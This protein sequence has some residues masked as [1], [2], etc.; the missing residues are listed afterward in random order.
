MNMNTLRRSLLPALAALA[1]AGS[2]HPVSDADRIGDV[3]AVHT[4]FLVKQDIVVPV[5]LSPD[6][7]LPPGE[8]LPQYADQHGIFYASPSGVIQ[9]S[10]EGDRLYP[11]GIHFPS[12]PDRYYTFPSLYVDL[13][14]LGITK[15]PLPASVRRSTW[16]SHVVFLLDGEPVEYGSLERISYRAMAPRLEYEGFS[17][18]RPPNDNWYI[19]RSEQE[20]TSVRVHRDLIPASPTHTFY[21]AVAI[22]GIERQPTS[23]A[24]FAEFAKSKGRTAPYEISEISYHQESTTKQGQ[25]CIR[26]E[27][28][29]AVRGAP[30][31]PQ[32]ELTMV[33]RG[34]RC[35]HPAFPNATLDFFYS[36]RGLP[37]E[38]DPG[39]YEEGEA[40]LRGVRIDIAPNT[41]AAQHGN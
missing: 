23:H 37:E 29:D 15:Y 18:D 24:E 9:R 4:S 19:L 1:C 30:V 6:Y 5:S 32:Q 31:A 35:L 13:P 20:Y 12:Q 3:S 27:S 11:G 33:I 34:F 10:D 22:G 26:V 40:F 38:L 2:P 28:V 36:E 25:W 14:V 17:F 8:Y 16:G 7:V 21:A 39:L 41:P